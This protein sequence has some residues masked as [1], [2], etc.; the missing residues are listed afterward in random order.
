MSQEKLDQ[1][2]LEI[3]NKVK[4]FGQLK[5]QPNDFFPGDTT[6]HPS[7]KVLDENELMTMVDA[8]LDGWLTTGRFND[9]FEKKMAT[10]LG[11]NFFMSTNSGSS[12]NLLAFSALTSDQLGDRSIQVRSSSRVG[13]LDYGVNAKRLNYIA[14]SLRAEGWD[15]VGVD[16]KTH[17]DYVAQ[18][19]GP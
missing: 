6:I 4:E 2:K 5:Y 19:G 13:Y 11:V 7:G 18:N 15:A 14:K 10:F 3:L 1:L 16:P 8:S 17:G 9:D 12:A